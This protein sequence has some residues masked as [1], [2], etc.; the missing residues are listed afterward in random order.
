[1]SP[2]DKIVWMKIQ[3]FANEMYLKQQFLYNFVIDMTQVKI[4]FG[5]WAI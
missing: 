2:D 1:M 3:L 5:Y 4:D